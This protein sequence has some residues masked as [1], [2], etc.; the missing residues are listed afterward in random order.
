[1]TKS[2]GNPKIP[3]SDFN[4]FFLKEPQTMMLLLFLLSLATF[5]Y[6]CYVLLRPEKF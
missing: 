3:V 1:M 2:E 5:G 4:L 6:L